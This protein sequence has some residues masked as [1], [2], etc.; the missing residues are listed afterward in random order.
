LLVLSIAGCLVT[1]LLLLP[2]LLSLGRARGRLAPE[3]PNGTSVAA[4][5]GPPGRGRPARSGADT[6]A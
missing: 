3:P 2:A 1:T 5:D 6:G 4:Q